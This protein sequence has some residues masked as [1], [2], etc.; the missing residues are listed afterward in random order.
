MQ[1]GRFLSS[2]NVFMPITDRD[3]TNNCRTTRREDRKQDEFTLWKMKSQNLT[4]KRWSNFFSPKA[5]E[6]AIKARHPKSVQSVFYIS[7]FIADR[8][9]V[10][11]SLLTSLQFLSVI[12]SFERDFVFWAWFR[13]FATNSFVQ[14]CDFVFWA[15]IRHFGVT[16]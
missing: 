6:L 1:G 2:H 12:S 10:T 13:I 16:S 3:H 7:D 5:S 4:Q 11:R 14:K 15:C 9:Y 8:F